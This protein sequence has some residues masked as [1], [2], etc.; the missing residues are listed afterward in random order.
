[1]LEKFKEDYHEL[2]NSAATKKG[3]DLVKQ[4]LNQLIDRKSGLQASKINGSVVKQACINMK[5]GKVDVTGSFSSDA[6]LN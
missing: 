5:A 6:L 2:Y 3:I 1:M 4:K